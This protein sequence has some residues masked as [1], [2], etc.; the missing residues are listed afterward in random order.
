MR[1][2]HSAYLTTRLRVL[3]LIPVA[4]ILRYVQSIWRRRGSADR[5]IALLER[6]L[7][8]RRDARG[9]LALPEMCAL[10]V[11][12]AVSGIF[13]TILTQLFLCGTLYRNGGSLFW[14]TD[15]DALL[16]VLLTA[17]V[18]LWTCAIVQGIQSTT[19]AG[20][21]RA[22]HLAEGK[23]DHVFDV[24]SAARNAFVCA[25]G[26]ML[27][28][29]CCLTLC[30]TVARFIL[31]ICV[32]L[33]F[34]RDAIERMLHVTIGRA[35]TVPAM[36][37][38]SVMLRVLTCFGTSLVASANT[39]AGYI[40]ALFGVTEADCWRAC[41]YCAQVL[42]TDAVREEA[43][44]LRSLLDESVQAL[45]LFAGAGGFLFSAHQL[46]VPS[47]ALLVGCVFSALPFFMLRLCANGLRDAYVP[48]DGDTDFSIDALTICEVIDELQV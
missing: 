48:S 23:A 32:I 37:Q 18:W 13:I 24:T 28:S 27:G 20:T 2:A 7:R 14:R 36:L 17:F 40:L 11:T 39:C 33:L 4:G 34:V 1:A 29:V 22:W 15:R 9:A 6:I 12:I 35:W 45:S 30:A 3:S 31:S 43:L 44:L 5:A 46:H 10:I 19:I 42:N 21:A 41:A 16:L 8:F 26:P 38:T 25:S 47:H